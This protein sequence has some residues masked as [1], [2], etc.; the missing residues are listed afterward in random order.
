MLHC[1]SGLTRRVI[2]WLNSVLG[3]RRPIPVLPMISKP[4]D[5][6]WG[7]MLEIMAALPLGARTMGLAEGGGAGAWREIAI[8]TDERVSLLC[9][10]A[11]SS[12][13]TRC[14]AAPNCFQ[15]V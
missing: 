15:G 14:A 6:M 10:H 4:Q 13:I 8:R 1:V 5:C 11:Q 7:W 12:A 9:D 3:V 2:T